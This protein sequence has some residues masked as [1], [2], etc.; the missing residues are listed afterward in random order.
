[1]SGGI[2]PL[3]RLNEHISAPQKTA[4]LKSG[5]SNHRHFSHS[6]DS[7]LWLY[8]SPDT[9]SPLLLANTP[10]VC[11]GMP[12]HMVQT[13]LVGLAGN[14]SKA[15]WR[16][17]KGAPQ[18]KCRH[19]KPRRTSIRHG[20]SRQPEPSSI[21][22]LSYVPGAAHQQTDVDSNWAVLADLLRCVYDLS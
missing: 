21:F 14:Q 13:T 1:M 9:V 18:R 19:M 5:H 6:S 4:D 15:R 10:S 3:L 7:L 2:V 20:S 8:T 22:L 12:V 16:Y 11:P 17:K